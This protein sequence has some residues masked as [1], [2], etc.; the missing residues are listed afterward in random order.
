MLRDQK[1]IAGIGNA[2]SDEVLHAARMSPFRLAASLTDDEVAGLHAAI[3]STL[4][5][6]VDR[7]ASAGGRRPE[8]GEEVRAAG[9]RPDRAALPGMRRHSA[10]GV[11]RGFR[12]AVLRHL[13]DRR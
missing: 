11:L 2:Y 8:G 3:V 7:S 4:R 1:I 12:A 5:E 13:P 10:R 9:A 6:A